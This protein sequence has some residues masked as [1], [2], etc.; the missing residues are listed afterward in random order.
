[1]T[2][3]NVVRFRVR[4]GRDQDFLEAHRNMAAH[5]PGFR[6]FSLVR[7]GD[8]SYCLIGEWDSF[9]SIVSARPNMLANL[10]RI[11]DMLLELGGGL[12]LTDP[13]SG[14]AVLDRASGGMRKR[15]SKQRAPTKK[16][17]RKRRA[18]K[19]RRTAKRR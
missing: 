17:A 6:R 3:F 8:G 12:G 11:R 16:P 10:D 19:A 5:F 1:M 9:D 7:T 4:P 13:V 2:A 14:E 18:K 15:K